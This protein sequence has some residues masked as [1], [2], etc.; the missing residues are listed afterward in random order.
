VVRP[1]SV[2][3][4]SRKKYLDDALR[5][6]LAGKGGSEGDRSGEGASDSHEGDGVGVRRGGVV[7]SALV[8]L[9]VKATDAC[10][11]RVKFVIVNLPFPEILSTET[12]SSTCG[13]VKK[14]C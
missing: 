3:G 12:T 5:V 14:R 6:V 1:V 4:Q 13:A 7:F 10:R 9:S 8:L 2:V 11:A